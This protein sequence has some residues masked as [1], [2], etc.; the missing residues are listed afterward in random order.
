MSCG[1]FSKP[2]G[3]AATMFE[4]TDA[5][6]KHRFAPAAHETKIGWRTQREFK[7]NQSRI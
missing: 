3:V 1:H 4:K 5:R 7:P 6:K 2:L